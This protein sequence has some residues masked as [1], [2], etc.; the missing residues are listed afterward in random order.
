MEILNITHLKFHIISK[1]KGYNKTY[2]N[3]K[4]YIE[5]DIKQMIVN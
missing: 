3:K 2:K 5:N 1:C 4:L